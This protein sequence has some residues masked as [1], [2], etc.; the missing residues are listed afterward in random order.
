MVKSYHVQGA[1]VKTNPPAWGAVS[2]LFHS[3]YCLLSA[4]VAISDTLVLPMQKRRDNGPASCALHANTSTGYALPL[5]PTEQ[6]TAERHGGSMS[7]STVP[8]LFDTTREIDY[9]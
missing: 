5:E 2:G 4:P 3:V 7:D 1:P 8:E 6:W 9:N